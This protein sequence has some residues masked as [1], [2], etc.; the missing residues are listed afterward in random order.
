MRRILPCD[1]RPFGGRARHGS[2]AGRGLGPVRSVPVHGRVEEAPDIAN[3]VAFGLSSCLWSEPAGA[4]DRFVAESE[5]GTGHMNAGHV[6][7]GP[8]FPL[9]ARG[10]ARSAM[11]VGGSIGPS[12]I[13]FH[14]SGHTVYRRAKV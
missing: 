11:G 5:S 2:R 7:A 6:N 13:R 4:T 3:D 14:T 1:D 12:T 8:I 9:S 10:T